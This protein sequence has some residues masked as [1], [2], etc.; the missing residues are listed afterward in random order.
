[1]TKQHKLTLARKQELAAVQTLHSPADAI[2][3]AARDGNGG[4]KTFTDKVTAFLDRKDAPQGDILTAAARDQAEQA[5][6]LHA[7][8]NSPQL[9]ALLLRDTVEKVSALNLGNLSHELG[10]LAGELPLLIE[11]TYE[12]PLDTTRVGYL[13]AV[14]FES[15]RR[16]NLLQVYSLLSEEVE[17]LPDDPSPTEQKPVLQ[18]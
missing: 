16:Y 6:A 10:A 15:G 4:S 7:V 3:K 11:A 9:D 8:D 14:A 18:M 1:M 12:R 17:A 13:M 2:A 5:F